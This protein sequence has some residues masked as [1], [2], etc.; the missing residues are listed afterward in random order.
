MID[1]YQAHLSLPEIGAVGQA[2]LRNTRILC[3]GAGGLAS[4][5]L[6]YLAGA[7]S[8][9]LGIVDDDVISLNNLPR[10]VLYNNQQLGLGKAQQAAAHL[11]RLNSDVAIAAFDTRLTPCNALNLIAQADIVLDGSD[12]F[13]TKFLI[14]DACAKLNKPW[15]YGAALGWQGQ[16]A[17]FWASQGPCYR[18]LYNDMPDVPPQSCATAGVIGPVPGT[19]GM[20][21]ALEVIKLALGL[22][23]CAA[24][25][26]EIMLGQVTVFDARTMAFQNLMLP[27]NPACAVCQAAPENIQLKTY[28]SSCQIMREITPDQL[29]DYP[30][31]KIID[32]RERDEWDR[33]NIPGAIHHAL[34]DINNG[35]FP[36]MPKDAE[37]ILQCQR[38]ARSAKALGILQQQGFT[39]LTNLSGGYAAW[40]E[41]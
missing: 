9:W 29:K 10:Q 11:S 18:C 32:V 23:W 34:S 4:A 2:R 12:N 14:N 37:I 19:I 20:L 33:G 40:S 22:D 16:A 41:L 1:R 7:G 5:A 8:G 3:V 24:H 17:S 13:A 38:G 36:D 25:G 35:S 6:P 26:L 39:N 31:A 28:E 27:K 15:V 30:N 21:Q